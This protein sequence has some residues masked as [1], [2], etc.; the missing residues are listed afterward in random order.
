MR[1]FKNIRHEAVPKEIWIGSTSCGRLSCPAQCR[2]IDP[3]TLLWWVRE[4][5][6]RLLNSATLTPYQ[7]SA[8]SLDPDAKVFVL[9]NGEELFTTSTTKYVKEV[10][11]L[12]HLTE[13]N[14]Y[15]EYSLR[16]GGTT[17][18][19]TASIPDG[20]TYSWVQWSKNKLPDS[21]KG[22]MQPS[23]QQMIRMPEYLLHGFVSQPGQTCI[24]VNS[25]ALVRDIW[26]EN[27][28]VRR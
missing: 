25:T 5:R 1:H 28:K 8:L 27:P 18:A 26:H 3:F 15:T 22:Y 20:Y 6:R 23:L 7:R 4:R 11:L 17:Q 13:L 21:A 10:A 24:P 14:R 12:N 2:Y 9:F 19:A 16:V